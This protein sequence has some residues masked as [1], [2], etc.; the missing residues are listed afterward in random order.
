MTFETKMLKFEEHIHTIGSAVR[1]FS[2]WPHQEAFHVIHSR[3]WRGPH[4]EILP[5]ADNPSTFPLVLSPPDGSHV[6]KAI[7]RFPCTPSI[8]SKRDA[9]R[10]KQEW[11]ERR[12][13][14][15]SARKGEGAAAIMARA[16]A[17]TLFGHLV[18]EF[19]PIFDIA[20]ILTE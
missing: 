13:C 8:I 1:F 2:F 17:E 12:F 20:G 18:A 14:S 16:K 11:E 9:W 4:V 15:F 3:C 6:T 19:P 7:A 5:P 10:H